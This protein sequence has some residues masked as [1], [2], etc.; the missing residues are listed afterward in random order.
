MSPFI[1]N[2]EDI[3]CSAREDSDFGRGS[4]SQFFRNDRKYWFI[5]GTAGAVLLIAIIG[6]VNSSMRSVNIDELPVIQ[7]EKTP[8]KEKPIKNNQVQHQDKIIYDN[9][10]GNYRKVEEK[11]AK[12]PETVLSFPEV[13]VSESLSIEDKQKIIQAFD[14]LAPEKE[15]KIN[16]I[17]EHPPIS[18]SVAL[19]K[20]EGLTAS[21]NATLR[22]LKSKK[23]LSENERVQ[24]ERL[25][26]KITSSYK[27]A[28]N[29]NDS[30]AE[31][32]PPI[33][34]IGTE[35]K[36]KR[37]RLKDLVATES[38]NAKIAEEVSRTRKG[39]VMVQ[40]ASVMTKSGAE[41]EYNRLLHKNGFLKG[42][43]KKIYKVDLGPRKG[44]RYRIQVG[45]FKNKAEARKIISAL[46]DNGCS[47]YISK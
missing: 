34:N 6:I 3:V 38:K 42:K 31:Q 11:L 9:I 21:E 44:V 12:Q 7:A 19:E 43:G 25:T 41:V 8:V 37:H 39:T 40:I 5:A 4:V 27:P 22:R 36:K 16:Y 29:F 47:A 26:K 18:K 45:P 35:V 14:D 10:S 46:R 20:Y 17:E 23:K 13:D 33:N 1:E 24:L 15:Y 2:E 28:V 30:Q 32:L